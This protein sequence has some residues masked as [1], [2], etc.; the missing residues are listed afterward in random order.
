MSIPNVSTLYYRINR[1]SE[2][3]SEFSRIITQ[4]LIEDSIENSYDLKTFSDASGDYKG[5][6]L[7]QK[8]NSIK[9][10][11]QCKFYPSPF[12][13]NHK[14][15]IK[16]AIKKALIDFDDMDEWIL[17]TPEDGLKSDMK[18]LDE[19]IVEFDITICHWGHSRIVN[20]MLKYPSISEKYYPE[21]S[22]K[23]TVKNNSNA[24]LEEDI[25]Y[26][27]IF[28]NPDVDPALIFLKA[29]P[30]LADCKAIFSQNYYKEFSDF[31]YI[32]YRELADSFIG[33][34]NSLNKDRFDIKSSTYN[35]IL[36]GKHNLPGGM[37]WL[38]NDYS[39]LNPN[40]VFYV[41]SFKSMNAEHGI[42]FSVW[43][44]INNRWVFFPKP[45]RA[46]SIINGM[47]NDKDLNRLIKYLKFFGIGKKLQKQYK[48]GALLGA[49]HII[50]KLIKN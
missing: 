13:P 8:K 47:N 9:K 25:K 34:M 2:G 39:A 42:S 40:S 5:V 50:R 35:E 30:T 7:I 15:E 11:I 29:Q 18:W 23:P 21:F 45:W 33:K 48:N 20:L 19:L 17:I 46:I 32:D 22:I 16:K 37:G 6:D 38:V 10:G 36:N 31:Y 12:S 44:F 28:L 43:C 24:P 1:G 4:L 26:F 3:G 14:T 49:N 27:N 41:V